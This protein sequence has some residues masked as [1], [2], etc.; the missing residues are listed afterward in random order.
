[1]KRPVISVLVS[2]G[3]SGGL[4]AFNAE[5]WL[6]LKILLTGASGFV[7]PYLKRELEANGHEV[8]STGRGGDEPGDI[9]C[10]I[11]SRE[12]V[13]SVFSSHNPDAV[14]HLAGISDVRS[15][16]ENF[17]LVADVNILGTYNCCYAST[18]SGV[19]TFLYVSTGL[20][21]GQLGQDEDKIGEKSRINILDP[22]S[23]SKFAGEEIVRAF[24]LAGRIDGYVVRPFN[25]IGPGQSE[26]FV[27]PSLARRIKNYSGG[28]FLVG[29]LSSRRDFTD[30]RDIVRGYR[31]LLEKRPNEK[32][33]VMGSGRSI[34]VQNVCEYLAEASGKAL[35]I[36]EDTSFIR[37][38]DAKD[39]VADSG[40]ASAVFGWSPDYCVGETIKEVY[41]ALGH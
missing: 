6:V 23:G 27:V 11:T 8:L 41:Q 14:V 1:M 25:H 7:G 36:R 12:A 24:D 34:S 5:R 39:M 40:L 33:F 38:N 31:Q 4:F 10:D 20:V 21:H 18:V 3:C 22:Y 35:D 16:V 9:E 2:F 37:K 26:R 29:N 32:L 15:A 19:S 28:E 17:P 30:V 13:L